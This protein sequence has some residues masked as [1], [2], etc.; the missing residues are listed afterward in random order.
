MQKPNPRTSPMRPSV[1]KRFCA[2]S[3]RDYDIIIVGAG[4]A[5]AALARKLRR[6]RV[7]VLEKDRGHKTDSGIVS[8]QYDK[9]IGKKGLIAERLY[10]MRFISPTEKTFSIRS[11]IPF[12]YRLKRAEFSQYL[13]SRI[14]NKISYEKALSVTFS[15]EGA[16]VRT[17]KNTYTCSV[18]VGCDGANSIVREAAGMKQPK[19]CYGL[20]SKNKHPELKGMFNV[21]LNKYFSPDF[22]AWMLS[23]E[24]GLISAIRSAEYFSF[25]AKKMA[26]NKKNIQGAAI[27]IGMTKSYA[28]NCL[29]LGDSAGQTK[30]LT[31]G[32][33]IFSLLASRHA[34]EVIKM[35]LEQDYFKGDLLCLYEKRW[36]R[37][38]GMEIKKQLLLRSMYRWLTNKQIDNLFSVFGDHLSKIK[39]FDYDR[40]SAVAYRMPKWKMAR[41]L[42]SILSTT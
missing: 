28:D 11:D 5:G 20:I 6:G 34:A 36:K 39:E 23:D 37:E 8:K 35:A 13:R 4:V 42:L 29:L 12:A 10:E 19:L 33:I 17:P 31:G 18:V 24:Y 32:G 16:E 15:K 41:T 9:L 14:K 1:A 22:F 26:T 40:L 7:L 30:P 25:F 38:I 21:Y 2:A 27:P 3:D